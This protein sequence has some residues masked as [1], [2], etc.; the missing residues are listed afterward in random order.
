[1]KKFINVL[2][3]PWGEGYKFSNKI[4]KR[5][6]NALIGCLLIPI[7]FPT[8]PFSIIIVAGV[9]GGAALS[10]IMPEPEF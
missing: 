3:S 1:M 9:L 4:R 7:V 6:I 5:A 8:V 10:I 2:F